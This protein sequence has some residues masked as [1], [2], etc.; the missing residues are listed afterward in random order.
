MIS[1]A[2]EGA[3]VG[4]HTDRYD[5]F[6]LQ[7]PGRRRWRLQHTPDP[8]LDERAEV[9]ILA[10]F[11]HEV[12]YVLEPGDMLYLPPGVAHDG[13]A[14]DG[15]CLTYSIGA[16]APSVE[17]LQQNWLG[18]LSQQVEGRVDLKAMYE[19]RD[20][21]TQTSPVEIADA[22]VA[23]VEQLLAP[24]RQ[25]TR[26]D[27]E[28]FLGRLLTGPKPHVVFP[29]TPKLSRGEVLQRLGRPESIGLALPSRGLV[30]GRRV[31]LNGEA[32]VVDDDAGL[33][34]WSRLVRE[35][36]VLGPVSFGGAGL[37]LLIAAFAKGFVRF[38][39]GGSSSSSS[40]S[41]RRRR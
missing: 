26:D 28:D 19:D 40:S 8:R 35:R 4:P 24:V 2:S 31:F 6:L 33:Q 9:P 29:P 36:R 15:P 23:R 13:T 27:V 41:G 5:V 11:K 14:V 1:W 25:T 16:V 18:Y 3:G 10:R 20:L 7:G 34:F 39:G 12:E 37:E 22:M 38:E 32:A 21:T 17:A 30:R